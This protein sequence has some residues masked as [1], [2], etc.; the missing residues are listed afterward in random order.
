MEAIETNP[1]ELIHTRVRYYRALHLLKDNKKHTFKTLQAILGDHVNYPDSVC[2]HS[3][4]DLDP[5][6]REKTIVSMVMDLS[7]RK[8]EVAWGNPCA[9]HYHSYDAGF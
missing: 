4:Y 3:I 9:N 5:L 1:D 8:M 6:D 2:N 7:E